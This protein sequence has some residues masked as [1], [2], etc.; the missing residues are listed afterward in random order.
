MRRIE[1]ATLTLR[2][3]TTTLQLMLL[4]RRRLLPAINR[5]LV[6]ASLSDRVQILVDL[7]LSLR[8]RLIVHILIHRAAITPP[9]A[10][11]VLAA[12]RADRAAVVVVVQRAVRDVVVTGGVVVNEAQ[13]QVVMVVQ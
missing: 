6:R 5:R 11:H 7:E 8:H 2:R 9:A 1:K 12:A 3:R 10:A 4:R 13:A